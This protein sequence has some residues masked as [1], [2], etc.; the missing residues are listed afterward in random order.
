MPPINLDGTQ[1]L[2]RAANAA[3]PGS[4]WWCT[5]FGWWMGPSRVVS[6]A[7]DQSVLHKEINDDSTQSW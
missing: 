6:T 5:P 3:V 7:G 2:R 1:R 4:E